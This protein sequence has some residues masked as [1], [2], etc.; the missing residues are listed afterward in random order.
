MNILNQQIGLFS[1][2]ADIGNPK[3]SG[4]VLFNKLEQ[5]YT[6]E[7]SGK[8]IWLDQD[9][10]HFLFRK[11]NGN[12]IVRARFEFVGK[13][14]ELHRKAGWIIRN[15]LNSNSAQVSTVI[16]GNGLTS[17]QYRKNQGDSIKEILSKQK[18]PNVIQLERR[19]NKFIMSTATF[20]F[21]LVT[22]DT[23]ELQL[24]N[25][26][27]AGLFVC[28]HNP[29]VTEKV[30]FTDVRIVKPVK[31]GFIPYTD[32]IGS[33]ME[34]FDTEKQRSSI[35]YST[36]NGIE[37]PNWPTDNKSLIYN[38]RGLLYKLNF[39][40]LVP[41][42]INTDFANRNNNDHVLSWDNKYMGI[43][44]HSKDDNGNSNVYV[45]PIT[46]GTP[47]R[48]TAQGPSYFHGWSP[49]DK[50]LI[51]CGARNDKYDIYKI[52][53]EGGME[54]QLT[55]AEGLDDGC[56]Y[57]PDGKYIYFHSNRT[58]KMEI[59][60]MKPDGSEQEQITKDNWGLNNWFPHISP[61]GKWIVFISFNNDV[62]SGDHPY[63]KHVYL[64][65]MPVTGGQA[66][67]VSYLYGGQGTIN[68]PSWSPDSKKF[69][70]V[71]NSDVLE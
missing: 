6:I 38:S 53:V 33:H 28:S 62:E 23:L 52:P 42:L 8:N 36:N 25:E 15:S 41:E 24:E 16:H 47:K 29:D 1:N 58:G 70:F 13:G 7:G 4:S 44:H 34:V 5:T 9:E 2:Q 48:I 32:Y 67:I 37:A 26:I 30:I 63:Y 71:S 20:G 51:Y 40:N 43:S 19:G 55:N 57:T 35:L 3:L 17:F 68:V 10:F 56:E 39:D 64:R 50:F 12:F 31:E 11:L 45:V 65:M 60:R 27:Y 18:A 61:D 21:P 14:V 69:A 22:D 54:V 49:D 66:K 59:W 46:G